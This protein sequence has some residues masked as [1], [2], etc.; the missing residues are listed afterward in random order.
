MKRGPVEVLFLAFPNDVGLAEM[1]AVVRKPVQ[2]GVIRLIDCVVALRDD[3]GRLGL[4]DLEDGL[5]AALSGL[6]IDD[7]DL[8]SD[9]D[10]AVLT[11]SLGDDQ[12]GL[13]LVFEEVWAREAVNELEALGA[14]VA[15]FARITPEDVDAAFAAQEARA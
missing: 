12:Q 1:V 5:P 7:N 11:D 9:D 4:L 10:L 6:D 2:A 14:E 13:A 15:L 3:S 8:L